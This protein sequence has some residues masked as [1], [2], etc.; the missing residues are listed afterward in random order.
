MTVFSRFAVVGVVTTFVIAHLSADGTEIPIR[1]HQHLIVVKGSVNGRP[2]LNLVID[3]GATHS[4]VS[5]LHCRSLK[6]RTTKLSAVSWGKKVRVKAGRLDSVAIGDVTFENV[7]TQV[8]DVSL[9]SGLRID[10]LVGLDLLRRTNVTI[11]YARRVLILGSHE[12][13]P[14]QCPFYPK[15]P[16]LLMRV[17]VQGKSLPMI[18]DTGSPYVVF[19]RS[20]VANKVRLTRTRERQQIAHAAGTLTLRKVVL[21]ETELGEHNLGALTAYL[22]DTTSAP[23]GGA[24]GILGPASLGLER[25]HLDFETNRIGWEF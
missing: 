20:E 1:L 5:N 12:A 24:A 2:D 8:G 4:V 25:L 17:D 19:F 10:L 22:M 16:F 18:L 7:E 6:I 21:D 11:D 3:T 23:Y 14:E 9:A 13:L 15:L